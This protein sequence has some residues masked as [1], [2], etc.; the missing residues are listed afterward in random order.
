MG[1]AFGAI[2]KR[3]GGVPEWLDIDNLI[4]L[5]ER[6]IDELREA[7][8]SLK[9]VVGDER[10]FL[11]RIKDGVENGTQLISPLLSESHTEAYILFI[12]NYLRG[13]MR[14]A[15]ERYRQQAFSINLC[16]KYMQSLCYTYDEDYVVYRGLN[17]PTRPEGALLPFNPEHKVYSFTDDRTVAC[18]FAAMGYGE[19]V[20]V[21]AKPLAGRLLFHYAYFHTF[22]DLIR[23]DVGIYDEQIGAPV[24]SKG[25]TDAD[26]YHLMPQREL[27]FRN[28]PN[29][30]Q[31]VLDVSTKCSPETRYVMMS[32]DAHARAEAALK[33][34]KKYKVHSPYVNAV[35]RAVMER[36]RAS[37]IR[38]LSAESSGWTEVEY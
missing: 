15:D 26:I 3:K 25:L 36:A 35:H 1:N 37:G 16:A 29:F 13:D 12:R 20:L 17:L 14:G 21:G 11:K 4:A 32:D 38:D 9:E 18:G 28:G 23:K 10:K 30:K 27:M 31:K 34:A 6:Q 8:D 22:P 33:K 2:R 5:D 19:Q 24:V 7:A